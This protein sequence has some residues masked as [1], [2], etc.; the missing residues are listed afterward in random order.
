MKK[1]I[2]ILVA[3]M[4]TGGL[5]LPAMAKGGHGKKKNDAATTAPVAGKKTGKFARIDSNGDKKIS[6][7]EFKAFRE[8]KKAAK[9]AAKQASGKTGKHAKSG[10]GKKGA[11][12]GH[13]KHLT[14]Q[15]RFDRR[16]LNHDGKI[17]KKEWKATKVKHQDKS[18]KKAHGKKKS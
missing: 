12:H 11:K 3:A 2:V 5:V 9:M 18:G 16:D 7:E 6:F 13:K 4:L 10:K 14:I 17:T 1:L 15:E 8:A